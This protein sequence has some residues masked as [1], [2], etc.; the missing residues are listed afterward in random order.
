VSVGIKPHTTNKGNI[1]NNMSYKKDVKKYKSAI[2]V[3]DEL[4]KKVKDRIKNEPNQEIW[5]TEQFHL[6]SVKELIE[7]DI[8]YLDPNY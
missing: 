3:I 1:R 5:K 8:P 4:L 7:M 6:D 2:K